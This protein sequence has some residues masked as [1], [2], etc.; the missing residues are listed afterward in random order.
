MIRI[1]CWSFFATLSP[2]EKTRPEIIWL[3]HFMHWS[4]QAQFVVVPHNDWHNAPRVG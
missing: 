2:V 3:G 1:H 4:C